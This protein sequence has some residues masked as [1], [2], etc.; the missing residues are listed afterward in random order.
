VLVLGLESSCDETGAAVVDDAGN[1]LSDVVHSQVAIHAPYGGVVPELASRDHLTNVGPVVTAALAKAGVTL[2]Q[3]GGIAVTNRPGLVGAL[4][5]G[6]QVAKGLAWATGKPLVGVDHLM[7]HLL[8]VFLRRGEGDAEPPRFPFV[9][10][11]VS[12]GH[13]AIY[14]VDA[15]RTDA[16]HELGATRDDAAGEAFDKVAKL[17]GLG[18]PGGPIVDRLA[19]LGDPSHVK[20]SAP[21]AARG[22]REMSFSGI[23]TQVVRLVS[24]RDG[25]RD[26]A[27]VADVCAAFQAA[28]CGVL[29][30]KTVEAAE[31]EGVADVVLGGG[32]AA[33]HELRRRT[34]ELASERGH[35]VLLPPLASCTDNAAM[36]AYAGAVRLARGER[37]GWDLTATSRTSLEPATRKGRGRR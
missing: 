27:W 7:G 34:T 21:M 36:I 20:L 12:G 8:S 22:V 30:R 18:Y 24:E 33:N 35:R 5:V 2:D 31:R 26:D 1:V 17:L 15:P 16:I 13:T 14:R 32:V 19:A 23:K 6:V 29:A 4:L 10:L 9:A 25:V 37:D 3:V 28:V 11:L